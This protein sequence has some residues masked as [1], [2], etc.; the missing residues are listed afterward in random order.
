MNRHGQ[1]LDCCGKWWRFGQVVETRDEWWNFGGRREAERL[2]RW[3][4]CM[5]RHGKVGVGVGRESPE[6]LSFGF[7]KC[8]ARGLS[9]GRW[10]QVV[11]VMAKTNASGILA[12]TRRRASSATRMQEQEREHECLR[13]CAEYRVPSA[14]CQK[15]RVPIAEHCM[16]SASAER[17][18]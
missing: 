15:L 5:Q 10:E 4:A 18:C 1:L 17:K 6:N 3:H 11:E 7:G 13:A 16:P 2:K 14:E 12:R 8:W 9:G